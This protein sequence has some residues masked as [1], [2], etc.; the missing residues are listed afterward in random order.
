M[1]NHLPV[2]RI[3]SGKSVCAITYKGLFI[4]YVIAIGGGGVTE[5]IIFAKRGG[6]GG[7]RKNYF[8]IM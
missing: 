8:Y 5:K 4:N 2:G 1:A 3:K 7:H 6:W